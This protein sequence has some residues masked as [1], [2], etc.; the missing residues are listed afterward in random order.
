MFNLFPL[1]P[2]KDWLQVKK[3]YIFIKT[4]NFSRIFGKQLK[5]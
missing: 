2:F 3:K 4:E 1:E 5:R